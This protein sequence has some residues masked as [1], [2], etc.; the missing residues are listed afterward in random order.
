MQDEVITI[1]GILLFVNLISVVFAVYSHFK[2]PQI[3]TEELTSILNERFA[4]HE[5]QQEKEFSVQQE[6]IIDLR[7]AMQNL[8]DN[9][10]HTITESL[11]LQEQRLNSLNE[12]MVELKTIIEVGFTKSLKR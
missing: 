3:K 12:K 2:K 7:L 4:N 9:D 1:G 6:K 10:L 8:K 11:R 5:K